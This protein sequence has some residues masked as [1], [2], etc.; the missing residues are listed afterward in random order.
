MDLRLVLLLLL[1]VFSG[2]A[3]YAQDASPIELELSGYSYITPVPV[4]LSEDDKRWL[5]QKRAL[6]VGVYQ[7]EQAPLVQTTLSGRYRGMNADYLT[8]IHYSLNVRI[9]VLSDGRIIADGTA[10]DLT[11]LAGAQRLDDAFLA[12]SETTPTPEGYAA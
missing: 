1:W 9:A 12:I 7:P 8:L 6:R 2:R 5:L 11:A 4:Y 3:V 10:A